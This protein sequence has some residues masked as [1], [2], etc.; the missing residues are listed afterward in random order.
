MGGFCNDKRSC[1]YEQ[2]FHFCLF[3]ESVEMFWHGLVKDKICWASS[4]PEDDTPVMTTWWC[5]FN[6]YE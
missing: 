5:C 3:S 2:S 1:I 4:V 6:M